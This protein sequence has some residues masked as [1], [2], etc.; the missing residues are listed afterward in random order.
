MD[1]E[2]NSEDKEQE[3]DEGKND[4]NSQA[5]ILYEDKRETNEDDNKENE[6][7]KVYND[8]NYWHVE[9]INLINDDILKELE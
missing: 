6:E 2:K 8:V 9:I 5:L 1:I 4:S 7:N 3:N